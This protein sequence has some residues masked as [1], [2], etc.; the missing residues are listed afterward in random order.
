[1]TLSEIHGSLVTLETA[2]GQM[3]LNFS[4]IDAQLIKLNG[5]MATVQTSIGEI[6][7][8]FSN[9]ELKISNMDGKIVEIETTLGNLQGIILDI[10]GDLAFV[11]TNIGEIQVL[12]DSYKP[13][14]QKD[15]TTLWILLVI[16]AAIVLITNLVFLIKHYRK[17]LVTKNENYAKRA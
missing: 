11:K 7:T 6:E 3:C 16:F 15:Q 1:M 5:N 13:S 12:L 4:Q 2:V 8:D 17:N 14:V 10:K 9:I